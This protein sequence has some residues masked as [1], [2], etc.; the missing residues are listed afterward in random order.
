MAK[1]QADPP[2]AAG[3][4]FFVVT[5]EDIGLAAEYAIVGEVTKGIETVERIEALGEG[6]GPPRQPVVIETIT[7]EES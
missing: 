4:Q 5:G 2:G 3:S 6:D 7:V 1:S